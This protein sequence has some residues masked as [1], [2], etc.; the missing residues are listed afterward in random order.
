MYGMWHATCC[1]HLLRDLKGLVD[2]HLIKWGE[3]VRKLFLDMNKHKKNDIAAGKKQCD[4]E[5]LAGFE[6]RFN[7]LLEKARSEIEKM[8]KKDFGYSEYNAM[9]NRLSKFEDTYLLFIRNYKAPFS[10]NLSER[11]LRS[12]KKQTENL[13]SVPKLAGN[14]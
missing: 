10:N 11:D 5:I 8:S 7:D 4:K 14:K 13:G 1:V 12:E 3:S 2:L 6:K 9:I